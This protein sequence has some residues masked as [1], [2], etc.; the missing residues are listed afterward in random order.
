MNLPLN[1]IAKYRTLLITLDNTTI[2]LPYSRFVNYTPY[3]GQS[4]IA[5]GKYDS[6]SK[7]LKVTDATSLETN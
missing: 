2:H 7:T 5:T 1:S 4:V 3:V 6:C